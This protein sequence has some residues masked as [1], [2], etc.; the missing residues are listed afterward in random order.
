MNQSSKNIREAVKKEIRTIIH[1]IT[2]FV[3]LIIAYIA[4]DFWSAAGRGFIQNKLNSDLKF[5]WR[6]SL[7]YAIVLSI[8][9]IIIAKFS[10]ISIL[11]L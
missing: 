9:V 2:F 10:D 11:K 8:I 7:F 3:I 4:L 5:T 6:D 1:P